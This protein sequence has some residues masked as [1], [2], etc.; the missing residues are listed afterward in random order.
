[1]RKGGEGVGEEIQ[2]VTSSLNTKDEE[3]NQNN[4]NQ[5]Q[6]GMIIKVKRRESQEKIRWRNSALRVNSGR[7]SVEIYMKY[8]KI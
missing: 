1:M 8:K 7:R 5:N 2:Q 4:D 3:A 6:N